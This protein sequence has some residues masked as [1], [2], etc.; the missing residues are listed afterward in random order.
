MSKNPYYSGPPSDHFDG[1]RFHL[2]DRTAT[3]RSFR[4]LWRWQREGTRTSWPKT[5]PVTQAIPPTRSITPRLTM[6]GH[7]TILIQVAGLNILTDP[8]WSDR[9]SPFRFVGPKRVTEPGVDFAQ[10]PTIDTVL[11]SHNHYDHFDIA[12]LR[13]LIL[14][15][16][17][18]IVT[19]LGNDVIVR[20]VI[21]TARTITGDWHDSISLSPDVSVHLTPANHWSSRGIRDRRMALWSGFWIDT[22]D[23][24]IWFAGDTGYGDGEIFHDIRKRYGA[25]H[26]A[27]IPIGAYEPRWFMSDQHVAPEQSVQIFHDIGAEQALGFH[28]GTFQLTDEG[29]EEPLQLLRTSLAASGVASSRFTAFAPGDVHVASA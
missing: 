27:M 3:D 24:Q 7:A 1:K 14:R 9:A 23:A 26:I 16:H 11:L 29:R 18:L 4:D 22:P 19:P 10:L 8:V 6:I 28:W 13:R 17:P 5:V 20:K 25:P 12:T 2:V 15:D 21:A